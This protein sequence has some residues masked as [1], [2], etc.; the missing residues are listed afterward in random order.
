MEIS[1]YQLL[2][3]QVLNCGMNPMMKYYTAGKINELESYEI[4]KT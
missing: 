4:S 3:E 2:E 1:Q